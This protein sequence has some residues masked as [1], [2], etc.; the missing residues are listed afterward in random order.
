MTNASD[1]DSG[2]KPPAPGSGSN[3]PDFRS[4]QL[5]FAAHIRNPEA[6]PRP[7][8]VPAQ[9]MQVY[10][11]L[12]YNNIEGFLAGA[13]PVAKRVLGESLWHQLARRFVHEHPSDSPY[14]LDISQE[15]LS[16]LDQVKPT[17]APDYLLELCHYEWVELSLKVDEREL[18]ESGVDGLGD[19][20]REPLLLNPLLWLL[21][22]RYPVQRITPE[23]VPADV[24]EQPTR[25]LVY[26][27]SLDQVRF[28]EL[29]TLAF[30]LVQQLLDAGD[31]TPS[32]E[33]LLEALAL[34]A[35]PE[36]AAARQRF[37]EQGH[38]LLVE[39]RDCEILLGSRVLA[40]SV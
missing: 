12:F 21:S 3:L 39:L 32:G 4:V 24:P 26:R 27:D 35:A 18:P 11:D 36:T 20:R 38:Q 14:F 22:Y 5:D 40:E 2:A 10:L 6:H 29:S 15:Y 23:F 7:A 33:A 28:R 13:F 17:E 8:D 37:L 34:Q 19:L 9:R 30:A 1:I 16:Y 25:L 31:S